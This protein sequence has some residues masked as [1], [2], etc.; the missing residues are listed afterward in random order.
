M[1]MPESALPVRRRRS[2]DR[3]ANSSQTRLREL[4][5][6]RDV[7]AHDLDLEPSVLAPRAVLEGAVIRAAKGE[8]PRLT[9][10]LRRWQW[11]QLEGPLS[12]LTV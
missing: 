2:T 3:L 6:Q 8:D 11:E 9:P 4:S 12:G 7:V 5:A 1:A 10:G